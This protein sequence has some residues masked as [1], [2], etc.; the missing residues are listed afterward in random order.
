MHV[1]AEIAGPADFISERQAFQF[2]SYVAPN[3]P[4]LWETLATGS[5]FHNASNPRSAPD[6]GLD[7]VMTGTSFD[8]EC[9]SQDAGYYERGGGAWT[10]TPF[11]AWF[12]QE[13]MISFDFDSASRPHLVYTSYQTPFPPWCDPCFCT[14]KS[15]ADGEET[16]DKSQD[17]CDDACAMS[18]WSHYA[19]RDSAGWHEEWIPNARGGAI[20]V[21]DQDVP[22]ILLKDGDDVILLTRD[23]STGVAGDTNSPYAGASRVL[24]SPN[25]SAR[26]FSFS[27]APDAG[28]SRIDIYDI[29]GRRVRSI[30]S[31]GAAGA[32]GSS[33]R[34]ALAWDGTDASG[35]AVAKGVYF[36]RF[37][38]GARV[39]THK[40][41]VIR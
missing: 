10:L 13:R 16:H 36:A 24:V 11:G 35:R 26:A 14:M 12:S 29:R 5:S 3:I 7:F 19:Y 34:H 6:G 23:V 2:A 33:A 30:Q 20:H 25:P 27:L 1:M 37:D 22:E 38:F 40:L 9:Q 21:D 18:G 41:T 15:G 39:E 8:S 28:L 4:A 32:A 31:P 17:E